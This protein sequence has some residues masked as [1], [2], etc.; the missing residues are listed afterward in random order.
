V[1]AVLCLCLEEHQSHYGPYLMGTL[2]LIINFLNH[3]PNASL[4]NA[5]TPMVRVSTL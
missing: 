4:P 2:I 1:R 3:L 5:V